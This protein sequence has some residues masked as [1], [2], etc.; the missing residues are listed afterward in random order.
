MDL[1]DLSTVKKG[2]VINLLNTDKS[3]FSGTIVREYKGCLAL[4]VSIKQENY[5]RL[6]KNEAFELIYA[7]KD[8]ATEMFFRSNRKFL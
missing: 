8:K 2:D 4:A 1:L 3:L 5:R 6:N 7:S